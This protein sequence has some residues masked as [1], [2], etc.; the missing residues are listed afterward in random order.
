[1]KKIIIDCP[2][3]FGVSL[4]DASCKDCEH[5]RDYGCKKILEANEKTNK[6][7]TLQNDM[8]YIYGLCEDC[9]GRPEGYN[10]PVQGF[11]DEHEDFMI[12]DIKE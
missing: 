4:L 7:T 6:V 3:A 12:L 9:E 11:L 8:D 1:M 10:C 5:L 2:I